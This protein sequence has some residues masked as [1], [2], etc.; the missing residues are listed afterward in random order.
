MMSGND[1]CYY[2]IQGG[3]QNENPKPDEF[4]TLKLTM[5]TNVAVSLII[6]ENFDSEWVD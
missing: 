3:D 1:M 4:L 6:G 2:E 5:L